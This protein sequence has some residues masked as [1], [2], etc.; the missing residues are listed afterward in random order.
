MTTRVH[1]VN[2]GPGIVE[3]KESSKPAPTVIYHGDSV[4]V[5]VYDSN[6]VSVTEKLPEKK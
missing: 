6:A 4:N 1:V 2:L 3:V 5:Y